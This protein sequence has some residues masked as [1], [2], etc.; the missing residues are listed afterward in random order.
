MPSADKIIDQGKIA[1]THCWDSGG[2]GAGAG[3][4]QIYRLGEHYAVAS[5]MAGPLGPFQSLHEAIEQADVLCITDAS[6]SIDCDELSTGQIIDLLQV[7]Y[8]GEEP[9]LDINGH[10]C[11]FVPE[12]GGYRQIASL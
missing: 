7:H 8:H 1:L 5:E 10:R 3:E 4:E 11:V 9:A 2:P 12:I 6:K